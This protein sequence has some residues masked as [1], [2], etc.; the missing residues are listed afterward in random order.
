LIRKGLKPIGNLSSG[1]SR[2]SISR[3]ARPR[4]SKRL[5]GS[6][7]DL[8]HPQLSI[9]ASH[10][11][12]SVPTLQSGVKTK[13][14]FTLSKRIDDWWNAVCTSFILNPEDKTNTAGSDA[15]S[16]NQMNLAASQPFRTFRSILAQLCPKKNP[17]D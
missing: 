8:A 16:I 5:T 1:A 6:Q 17:N 4:L 15:G 11:S 3:P 13:K 9:L 14:N 7:A 12:N 2:K 10:S